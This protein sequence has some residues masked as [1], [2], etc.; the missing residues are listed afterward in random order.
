MSTS[1]NQT[2]ASGFQFL[3]EKTPTWLYRD[4]IPA[5]FGEKVS[6]TQNGVD[7]NTRFLLAQEGDSFD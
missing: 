2:E 3:K 1:S 7:V 5:Y 4:F 6:N